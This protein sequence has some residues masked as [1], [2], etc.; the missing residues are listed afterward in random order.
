MANTNKV[1]YR[2]PSSKISFTDATRVITVN[3]AVINPQ[4]VLH[5]WVY[6]GSSIANSYDAWLG[7]ANFAKCTLTN[8]GYNTT[9]TLD[10]SLP[11]LS[12]SN[13]ILIEYYDDA[14]L[15]ITY[16][17]NSYSNTQGDFIANPVTATTNIQITNLN[18]FN[19][20]T[21]N[22]IGSDIRR[23]S[24]TGVTTTMSTDLFY[25]SVTGTT[26]TISLT[27]NDVFLTGDTVL[28]KLNGPDKYADNIS[29][30]SLNTVLNTPQTISPIPLIDTTN[31]AAGNNYYPSSDGVIINQSN[32]VATL[33][34]TAGAGNSNLIYLE[35]S[36]EDETVTSPANFKRY[37]IPTIIAEDLAVNTPSMP[38][39]GMKDLQE[40]FV[41]PG[42]A[43]KIDVDLSQLISYRIRFV[44]VTANAG[45]AT[46]KHYISFG[47]TMLGTGI[48]SSE[49]KINNDIRYIQSTL[50]STTTAVN[51]ATSNNT[52]LNIQQIDVRGCDQIEFFTTYTRNS[53]TGGTMQVVPCALRHS[54]TAD[55]AELF[56]T[57]NLA[58]YQ[59]SLDESALVTTRAYKYQCSGYPYLQVRTLATYSG[60]TVGTIQIKANR[61]GIQ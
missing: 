6:S 50:V 61:Y 23:I 30:T 52:W 29:N 32:N 33:W 31:V 57:D 16:T 19:L 9:I 25:I 15:P 12:S 36:D 44:V 56:T 26:Y 38:I 34:F 45:S 41:R 47:G 40:I 14:N 42:E 3:S 18:A 59:I 43:I 8:D 46:N 54:R 58:D 27:N 24:V 4:D 21:V 39:S 13:I 7:V 5:I 1:V 37:M 55:D 28:V 22:M 51:I 17:N 48:I 2:V 53:T 60:S 10:N 20:S 35:V 49:K 11:P